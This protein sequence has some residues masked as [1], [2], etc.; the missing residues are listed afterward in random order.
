MTTTLDAA[1]A[2]SSHLHPA[3]SWDVADHPVPTGREEVWRFTPVD[4]LAPLFDPEVAE[5]SLTWDVDLPAGATLATIDAAEARS[6]S[7]AAP[8]DRVAAVAA[9]RAQRPVHLS[10]APGV[11][12]DRPVVLDATGRR[13]SAVGRLIVTVGAGAQATVVLRY[14]GSASYAAKYDVRVGDGASVNL[15]SVQD[16]ADDALHGGETSLSVGRDARVRT[17]EVSLGGRVVRLTNNARFEGPGGSV[18]QFGLYFADAGQHLEHRLFV[19]HNEPHTSSNVDYRGALQGES[20]HSVWIGD[21]LIRK[22]AE[23]ISTYEQNRNLVLTD[24]CIA[25]S[26]PNLEIE[27][28]EIA[29]AGHSSTT[30]RFDDEQLFYLMS[31]GIPADEA[32]R[33]VVEGFFADILRRIG[34]G[35]I[36]EQLLSAVRAELAVTVG[37]AR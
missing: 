4:Q 24:G 28:G 21:V 18:E 2:V 8:A 14:R 23:G 13:E 22:E 17:V 20:A 5:A 16:W 26:V 19:D 35:E 32:K 33:L 7:V 29:G 3:T 30:G 11:V 37:V 12:L 36:E 1:P 27:T 9:A 15:V 25:D 6:L 10:I 34:V 31:R